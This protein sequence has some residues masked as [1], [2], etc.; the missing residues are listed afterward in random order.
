[1]VPSEGVITRFEETAKQH[2]QQS[3]PPEPEPDF[4]EVNKTY[5]ALAAAKE[6]DRPAL[7]DELKAE[8]GGF[9]TRAKFEEDKLATAKKFKAADLE[10]ARSQYDLAVGNEAPQEKL[11]ELQSKVTEQLQ[12]VSDATIAV[13][14]ATTFR[15]ELDKILGEITADEDAA[16]KGARRSPEL[17]DATGEGARNERENS[18]MK[19]ITELPIIDAF[20]RPI[21]IEQIWLP[22][23]TIN[24]NFGEVGDIARFDRCVTC[25]Q[26]IAESAPGSPTKPRYE[27]E[28]AM[29]LTL[30]TPDEKPAALAE[31]PDDPEERQTY[32]AKVMEETYGLQLAAQGLFNPDDAMISVVRPQTPGAKAELIHRRRH[33]EQVGDA[34]ILEQVVHL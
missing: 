22:K 14:N 26:A 6:E 11:D 18:L 9:V 13:E 8:L 2:A 10:V 21:K 28:H 15:K 31:A 23:L 32:Y 3:E 27:A 5:N 25:H 1:M 12:T 30:Q 17:G 16:R 29:T 34:A 19:E 33:R 7:L 20:G 4:A 24:Y